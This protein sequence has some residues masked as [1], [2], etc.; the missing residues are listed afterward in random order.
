MLVTFFA[1]AA[2]VAILATRNWIEAIVVFCSAIPIAVVANV[3]RITVT[4]ALYEANQNELARVI[5]HDV[6]GW[7]MMPLGLGLLLVELHI[8]GRAVVPVDG[9][10]KSA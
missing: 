9:P 4:G 5:F 6:A 3:A 7:L 8:L 10:T 1:L 2:A